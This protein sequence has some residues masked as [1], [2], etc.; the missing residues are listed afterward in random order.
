M[1]CLFCKWLKRPCI[2]AE[3]AKD[4][5]GKFARVSCYIEGYDRM[6]NA[7]PREMNRF[8]IEISR[9]RKEAKRLERSL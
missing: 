1:K 5:R 3:P 8:Q 7:N 6:F 4:L 2:C 9:F